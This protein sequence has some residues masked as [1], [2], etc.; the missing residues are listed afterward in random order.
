MK[1][2]GTNKCTDNTLTGKFKKSFFIEFLAAWTVAKWIR[3]KNIEL[4]GVH[5]YK[6]TGLTNEG[7]PSGPSGKHNKTMLVY[8]VF[9]C[10]CFVF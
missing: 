6:N 2:E 8:A 9:F 3:Y 1:K 7:T 4:E 10:C 5:K